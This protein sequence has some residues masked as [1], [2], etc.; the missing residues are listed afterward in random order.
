M[1]LY[2]FSINIINNKH[3]IEQLKNYLT[4]F[5]NRL[6][7]HLGIFLKNFAFLFEF[8]NFRVSCSMSIEIFDNNLKLF[9]ILI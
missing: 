3:A 4:F 1:F 6:E 8:L 9:L 2:L 5:E 7:N